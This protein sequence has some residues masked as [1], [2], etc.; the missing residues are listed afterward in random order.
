MVTKRLL[1]KTPSIAYLTTHT[2]LAKGT[3]HEEV[4]WG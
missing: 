4:A 3:G 1:K 2:P